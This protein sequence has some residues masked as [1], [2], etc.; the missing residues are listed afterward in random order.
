M[1]FRVNLKIKKPTLHCCFTWI[2]F[3]KLNFTVAFL[4]IKKIWEDC[5]ASKV[6]AWGILRNE[7]EILVMGGDNFEMGRLC[8][9]MDYV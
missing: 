6:G 7:G 1:Y 5:S 2:V 9:I 4:L 3:I 8:F